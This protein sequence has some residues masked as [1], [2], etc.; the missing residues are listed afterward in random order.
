M[1]V[2]LNQH[3]IEAILEIEIMSEQQIIMHLL[4]SPNSNGVDVEDVHFSVGESEILYLAS[5]I[6]MQGSPDDFMFVE[7]VVFY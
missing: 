7:N 4:A 3:K 6:S 2:V 1:A 5:S